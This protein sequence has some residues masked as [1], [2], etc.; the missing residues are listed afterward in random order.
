MTGRRYLLLALSALILLPLLACVHFV[1]GSLS[2]STW[3]VPLSLPGGVQLPLNAAPILRAA[4]SA[5]GRHLLDGTVWR[6]QVGAITFMDRNGGLAVQCT[7]CVLYWPAFSAAPIRMPSIAIELQRNGSRLYGTLT[8]TDRQIEQRI[9][10]NGELTESGLNLNWV[11]P[12][13]ALSDWF[14]FVRHAIPELR[15]ARI[16]GT[17]SANGTLHLPSN[18]WTAVPRLEGFEVHGLGTERLRHGTF[19]LACRSPDGLPEQR[20]TGDGVPGW[21]PLDKM[22]RWLP[23]AVLA[24]EDAH[25]YKHAGYDLAELSPLLANA[26]RSRRRGAST[27]TQ[28]LAKNFFVGAAG[29]GE[30]KLRE[31][32]YAVEMERTLGKRRIL[33]LYLNTVD[34][35]PGMCGVTDASR[36]YFGRGPASLA[37]AEASWLAGILRNPHQAYQ[38]EF[39]GKVI[40]RKRLA[41]VLSQLPRSFRRSR[42]LSFNGWSTPVHSQ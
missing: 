14:G 22:G 10:F 39:V 7:D 13:S 3:T 28:Q 4:S 33:T 27:I 30:R 16:L 11:L 38:A 17:L 5:W 15:D 41:W 24:A 29:T 12:R 25:F 31:L 6:S 35:G 2:G 18:K 26:E 42:E 19:K 32:L 40:A 36:T 37:S 23:L 34:W 1:L 21:L 20:V 9:F 8:A